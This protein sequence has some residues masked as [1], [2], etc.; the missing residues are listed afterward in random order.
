MKV[1]AKIIPVN[2]CNNGKIYMK[3]RIYLPENYQFTSYFMIHKTFKD[4]I[5]PK[6]NFG[7]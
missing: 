6:L 1:F 2:S 5:L 3:W 4:K 7:V